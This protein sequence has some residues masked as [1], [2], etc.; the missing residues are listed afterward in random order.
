MARRSKGVRILG[1]YPH[2]R[3]FRVIV[4]G[5]GGKRSSRLYETE[6][7]ARQVIRSLTSELTGDAALTVGDVM[8]RYERYLREEKQNKPLSVDTTL[9]RLKSFFTDEGLLFRGIDASRCNAYYTALAKRVKVDTHRNTLSEAR[10]FL[11][12]TVKRKLRASNPLD[13]VEGMGKRH[14]GKEQLRLDEA[15]RWLA[16]ATEQA[17]AGK[18]GAVAAMVTLLMGLR[19]SEVVQRTVRDVDDDGRLLW[20]PDSKTD[21]G[22]RRQQV[23]ELLQPYLARLA[24]GK[25]PMD[26]L[27]GKHD[28]AWPRQWVQ[29]LC[30]AAKVPVVTAHGMRG[31]HSTLA[32]ETG[33]TAHAVAAALGHESPATTFQ[34]YATPTAVGNARQERALR[35]LQ[36]GRQGS[37][38]N[39]SPGFRS[40]PSPESTEGPATSQ[41][42]CAI[43]GAEGDRTPGL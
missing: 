31:L 10:T 39:D 33:V 3:R 26:L 40:P 16:K 24:A 9:A 25:Q 38:G 34:H 15:R 2:R 19:A 30:A 42:P 37:V 1:P 27:F 22:R 21:A 29:R 32:I 13:S 20:I 23:P 35:V 36:G 14:K 43:S 8:E 12:W 6:K 4:V 7:Q 18:D 5:E 17:D 28:R 41:S 11:K